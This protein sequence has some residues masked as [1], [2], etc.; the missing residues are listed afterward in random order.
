VPED[1][2]GK[3]DACA[4]GEQWQCNYDDIP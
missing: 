3:D 1:G 4:R 2:E